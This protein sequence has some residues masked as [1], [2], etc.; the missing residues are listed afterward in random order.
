M[1]EKEVDE[2]EL[3]F[4]TLQKENQTLLERQKNLGE[5]LDTK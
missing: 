5:F 4:Q 1:K 2:L 3:K